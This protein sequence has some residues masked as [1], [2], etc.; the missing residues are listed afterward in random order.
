MSWTCHSQ[1]VMDRHR[2]HVTESYLPGPRMLFLGGLWVA[3]AGRSLEGERALV[4]VKPHEETVTRKD[5]HTVGSQPTVRVDGQYHNPQ[6]HEKPGAYRCSGL[7]NN[8]RRRLPIV[9]AGVALPGC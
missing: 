1:I 9:K 7:Q 2:T 5:C 6:A 8:P 4:S 3:C